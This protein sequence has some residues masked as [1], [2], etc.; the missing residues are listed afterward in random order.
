M[1]ALTRIQ[2]EI[3]YLPFE[4]FDL[5]TGCFFW[6]SYLVTSIQVEVQKTENEQK[7]H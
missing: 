4:V 6:L 5:E 2:K 3:V 1:S 7:Q